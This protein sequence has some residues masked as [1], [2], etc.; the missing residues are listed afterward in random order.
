MP[1]LKRPKEVSWTWRKPA[2]PFPQTLG[3]NGCF[4]APSGGGK[5]TTLV[6]LLI[7]PYTRVYGAAHVFSPS[8]GIDS[9]WEL[10]RG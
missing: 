2:E 1:V 3:A 5:T 8:V 4:L 7:G 10:R 9:A 6:S